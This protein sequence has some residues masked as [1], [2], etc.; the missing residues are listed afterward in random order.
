[1]SLRGSRARV[2]GPSRILPN[3]FHQRPDPGDDAGSQG[4]PGDEIRTR[5]VRSLRLSLLNSRM[6]TV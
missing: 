5:F 3:A 4:L 2:A 1:M 6:A